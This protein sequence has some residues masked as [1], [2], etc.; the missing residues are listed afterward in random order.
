MIDIPYCL[1]FNRFSA[2]WYAYLKLKD[3]DHQQAFTCPK[4]GVSVNMQLS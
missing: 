2:A 1:C 3:I 4:C